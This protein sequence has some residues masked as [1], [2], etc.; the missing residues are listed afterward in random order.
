MIRRRIGRAAVTA[1]VTAVALFCAACGTSGPAIAPPGPRIG[2]PINAQLPAAISDA[3]LVS[4][5][6]FRFTLASLRGKVVV[7]SDVMTLCQESCPLDTADVVAAARAAARNGLGKKIAFLS[8]TIDP[9]RDTPAQLAAYRRQ[10]APAPS[11]WTTATGAPQTLHAFWK[12]FGVYIKRVPDQPP[13]PRNWRTGKPLT[14]D[15]THSDEVFFLD[16]HGRE[17][18]LLDGVPH[19]APG[20]TIPPTLNKF[21]DAKGH[22]NVTSPSKLAWTLPQELRVLSWLTGKRIR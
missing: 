18:F 14:Y 6:G 8:I 11:D 20:T 5:S 4:S 10:F 9:R 7:V 2:Q 12:A 19:L 1:A 16:Q 3:V 13:L 21:L 22:Q 15:L 17:R